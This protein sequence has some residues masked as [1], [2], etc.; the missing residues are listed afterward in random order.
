MSGRLIEP[1][2]R[3]Q[4]HNQP[5]SGKDRWRHGYAEIFVGQLA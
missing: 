4:A 1:A 2:K 5:A 3:R